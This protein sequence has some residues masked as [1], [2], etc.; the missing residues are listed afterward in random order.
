M[1]R[2]SLGLRIQ[3]GLY[4]IIEL[5]GPE[6]GVVDSPSF[7]RLLSVKQ[8]GFAYA[9]FPGADF[10][11]FSHSIGAMHVMSKMLH[12]LTDFGGERLS[13]TDVSIYRLAALLHDIGHYPFSHAVEHAIKRRYQADLTKDEPGQAYL[14]HE[15]VGALILEKD[16]TLKIAIERSGIDPKAV[17]GVFGNNP[18]RVRALVSSD[19]D[20]DRL[21]YLLRTAHCSGLPYGAID[22]E[23]IVREARLDSDGRLCWT[24]RA[25]PALDHLLISRFYDYH[26]MA[27]NKTVVALEELLKDIVYGLTDPTVPDTLRLDLSAS[28]IGAMLENGKWFSFDDHSLFESIKKARDEGLST[29]EDPNLAAKC[30]ALIARQ[31]PRRVGEVGAM[32]P[33]TFEPHFDN[34]IKIV[35]ESVRRLANDFH[36][37]E[38]L[39]WV[40]ECKRTFTEYEGVE[41]LSDDDEATSEMVRILQKD[42]T[43]RLAVLDPESVLAQ[44]YR[45]WRFAIRVYVLI[46]KENSDRDKIEATVQKRLTRIWEEATESARSMPLGLEIVG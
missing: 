11:R 41:A 28:G 13:D 43:S 18:T 27:H 44:L 23:Y 36:I 22:Q 45:V 10:S 39:W 29:K 31:P 33:P 5:E 30:A 20:V 26:Q 16:P 7:Q 38:S 9:V 21:D 2:S 35:R 42:Q 8:L 4:G 19:V 40:W 1:K 17:I 24:A 34:A 14:K 15:G 32:L 46:P 3:D 25:L 6:R 12:A 37:P